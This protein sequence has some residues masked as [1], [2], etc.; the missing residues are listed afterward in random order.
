MLDQLGTNRQAWYAEQSVT[1]LVHDYAC[2]PLSTSTYTWR[3]TGINNEYLSNFVVYF[4]NLTAYNDTFANFPRRMCLTI[5]KNWLY[6]FLYRLAV[7]NHAHICDSTL[8]NLW[9]ATAEQGKTNILI[10]RKESCHSQLIQ[11]PTPVHLTLKKSQVTAELHIQTLINIC[12]SFIITRVYPKVS[13]L[14]Q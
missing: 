14:S 9:S 11:W 7:E 4:S 10:V 12:K 2:F 3:K 6:S 8:Y 1:K 5:H 13:G